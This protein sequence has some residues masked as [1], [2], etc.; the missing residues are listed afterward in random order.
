MVYEP[1]RVVLDVSAEKDCILILQDTDYPG[2]TA[3]VD[4]RRRP[5]EGTDLGVRALTLEAGRHTVEMEYK[6]SSLRYGLI[7]S[8][9]G[10]VMTVAYATRTAIR[11]KRQ[12]QR[13]AG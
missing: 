5:I 9:L 3:H 11:Q 13:R 7:L 2:W 1:E 4:G 12:Q 10:L 6:P 8:C